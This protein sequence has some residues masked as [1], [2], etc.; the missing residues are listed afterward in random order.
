MHT[1]PRGRWLAVAAFALASLAPTRSVS[2]QWIYEFSGLFNNGQQTVSFTLERAEPI[3]GPVSATPAACS[4]TPAV[5]FGETFACASTSFS[6]DGFGT[7]FTLVDFGYT[8]DGGGGGAFYW[9]DPGAL[10]APG[11]YTTYTGEISAPNPNFVAPDAP[12]EGL[13]EWECNDLRQERNFYGNAGTATLTVRQADVV[14]VPEPSSVALM[15][16]GLGVLGVA[17]RRRPRAQL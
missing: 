3:V 12:C 10:T 5:L 1:A 2:A 13:D 17:A 7:G 6:T 4:I 14:E 15:L 8:T 9:F 16:A 11:T